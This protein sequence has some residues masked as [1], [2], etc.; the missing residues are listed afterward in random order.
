[1]FPNYID[2]YRYL[3]NMRIFLILALRN[4]TA[5][6]VSSYKFRSI[7]PDLSP[8]AIHPNKLVYKSKLAFESRSGKKLATIDRWEKNMNKSKRP[9]KMN[10]FYSRSAPLSVCAPGNTAFTIYRV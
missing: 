6:S 1:M 7:T 2:Y 5:S 4:K 8:P 10:K 3:R 9:A